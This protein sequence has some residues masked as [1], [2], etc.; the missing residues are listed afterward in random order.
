MSD[1]GTPVR[2]RAYLDRGIA[3]GITTI[4][5]PRRVRESPVIAEGG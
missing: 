2:H 3:G 4:E 5:E 1:A